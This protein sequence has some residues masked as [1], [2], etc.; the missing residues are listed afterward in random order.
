[1]R[2]HCII[3]LSYINFIRGHHALTHSLVTHVNMYVAATYIFTVGR[4]LKNWALTSECCCVYNSGGHHR[5]IL[6]CM[7]CFSHLWVNGWGW[8]A[9]AHYD[10]DGGV[11]WA[12]QIWSH[13]PSC[14][15][16]LNGSHVALKAQSLALVF[17]WWNGTSVMGNRMCMLAVF[18]YVRETDR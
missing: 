17:I 7:Q 5:D 3:H 6:L 10:L 9:A 11:S 8:L 16:K 2:L 12:W 13:F 18:V 4:N 14:C 1:M 15:C